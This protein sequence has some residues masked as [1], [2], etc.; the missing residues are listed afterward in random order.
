MI[1]TTLAVDTIELC[2]TAVSTDNQSITKKAPNL[3]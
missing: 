3:S 1:F 2:K